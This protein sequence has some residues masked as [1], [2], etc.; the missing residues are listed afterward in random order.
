MFYARAKQTFFTPNS[1]FELNVPADVLAPFHISNGSPHPDPAV[2]TEVACEARA[3]LKESLHRFV[4]AAYTNVGTQRVM[5]GIVAGILISLAGGVPPI[6][7]NFAEGESRWLRLAALPGLWLGLT[8]LIASLHG[9]CL[10]VYLFGDLRQLRKF[11]LTR[12][13]ISR[14]LSRSRP[15]ISPPLSAPPPPPITP[16][17]H[18][19]LLAIPPPARAYIP[20]NNTLCRIESV[21]S[22]YSTSSSSSFASDESSLEEGAIVIS[23]AYYDDDPVEGPAI[24]PITPDANANHF[25]FPMK[26]DSFDHDESGTNSFVNTASFIHPFDSHSDEDLAYNSPKPSPEECQRITAFDFDALPPRTREHPPPPS[27]APS[28][29]QVPARVPEEQNVIKIERDLPKYKF[30]PRAWIARLQTRCNISKWRIEHRTVVSDPEKGKAPISP[31]EHQNPLF[32]NHARRR[33]Y[34]NP[35]VKV[36]TQFKLVKAVPAFASPLT[37]VLSPIVVRGQWEIVV[38]STIIALVL[39]W[40]VLGSLLAVPEVRR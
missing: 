28:P 27:P 24:S 35:E 34:D 39:S 36:R 31:T 3:M 19:P 8:I 7:V 1:D 16:L 12:P 9:V 14:P 23:P 32:P 30:S 33:S 2:F 13:P 10:G 29:V 22:Q 15:A 40:V 6:A 37:R 25:T 18:P 11:E 21:G 38:R 5:C 20:P 4:I 17:T 26:R